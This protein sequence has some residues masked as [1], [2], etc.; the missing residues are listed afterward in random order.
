MAEVCRY[1]QLPEAIP[2]LKKKVGMGDELRA[3]EEFWALIE[4]KSNTL[5]AGPIAKASIEAARRYWK[6][7]EPEEQH[8]LRTVLPRIDI[9]VDAIRTIIDGPKSS[10][11]LR[12]RSIE[13]AENPY[14][15]TEQ[16]VGESADDRL[17]WGQLDRAAIPSPQ[18]GVDAL[19]SLDSPQ[20]LRALASEC[21][22]RT[23]GHTFLSETALVAQIN[24]RLK[25]IPEWK[26]IQ[27]KAKYF[28]VDEAHYSG[29]LVFHEES[30]DRYVY[31]KDHFD[32][33]QA[34][35]RQ[36]K[37]LMRRPDIVLRIPMTDANWRDFLAKPDSSLARKAGAEYQLAV[38]SQAEACQRIF[39]KGFSVLCGAA[40][41]GKTTVLAAIVKA[42]RKVDGI[43][44][45]V[46]A[47]APTGKAA[48]RARAVF[49]RDLAA[50]GLVETSTVHSF[51]ARH[52]W[53]NDN[54]TY[55]RI[56]GERETKSQ[57]VI[58]DEC[59]MMD[60]HLFATLFRAM[61]WTTVKRVILVGDPNQ[62]PP[63]GTGKVFADIVDYCRISARESISEL[64]ANLRQLEGRV[65]GKG[66][67]IVD[68]ASLYRN[69]G[70]ADEKNEDREAAAEDLLRKVQGS[71]DVD[72]DL[73]VLYW[74]E[75]E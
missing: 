69:D 43:G 45:S 30:E 19:A 55:S 8:L 20:R 52:G 62:L 15:L 14:I 34:I 46:I 71:G 35:E 50:G 56:G 4:G 2:F 67:G 39:T 24:V 44:A 9:D 38:N 74:N 33:E 1:L 31:L 72:K 5:G 27:F 7:Q 29:A 68:L 28:E 18:L 40:G 26:R 42:I 10:H 17:T 54:L 59:S 57:T 16:Y 60:L 64:S 36:L 53:L 21:L 51:L 49:D 22:M 25:A 6:L 13:I 11:G 63:I 73:R 47:L 23:A 37:Q 58:I 12:A 32:A 41:T 70:L 3:V 65:D 61:D 48:D 75:P 66:T